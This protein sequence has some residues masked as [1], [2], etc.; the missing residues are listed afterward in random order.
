MEDFR[1]VSR[2][3]QK[4]MFMCS[5]DLKDAYFLVSVDNLY[6]KYLRFIFQGTLYE[7][8]CLPFGLSSAPFIFTKLT[9]PVITHLRKLG[10]LCVAYLDDFLI[11]GNTAEECQ[12]NTRLSVELF[13]SLGFIVNKD[14]SA[15]QPSH[16]R[17]FLGFI[18]NSH[19]LSISLPAEKRFKINKLLDKF[20]KKK[21]CSIREWASF[22][23]L[24]ISICPAVKYGWLYTK[25]FEKVKIA[26]L[27]QHNMNFDANIQLPPKIRPDLYWWKS[28]IFTSFN[29]IKR[30]SFSLEIFTDASLSGWGACSK[31]ES[32]HGWWDESDR[33]RHINYLELKAIFLGLKCFTLNHKNCNILVRSDNTTALSYINRMG[34]V[35]HES[36][37]KLSKEIW[38]F[39][40]SKNIFLVASYIS[41]QNNWRADYESRVLPPETEWSLSNSAFIKI[42]K[43]F[44]TPEIDLFA[45]YFNHKCT[46]YVS[47]LPDPNSIAIDAFTLK[48]QNL[49]FYMFPPFSMLLRVI[50]K[51]IQDKAEGIIVVPWWPTQPWFPLFLKY[52]KGNH[53]IFKPDTSLLSCPC[54][55][56]HPMAKHLILAAAILSA[57]PTN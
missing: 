49:F 42:V 33:Q 32:T 54:R 1:T 40:E 12:I 56:E 37:H 44:G 50:Q 24:L 2:I 36:L 10:I 9:K 55:T 21:D 4:D 51:I 18:F 27:L 53:I 35:Q 34:S 17:K 20:L 31:N 52:K 15:L 11:F 48:W 43:T 26:K 39:C 19:N 23:G 7:F 3:L 25:I 8:T 46:K 47:W 29:D 13:I 28:N 45:S 14:K 16:S 57:K 22:I 5:I 30:D 41:S 38:Q 6:R